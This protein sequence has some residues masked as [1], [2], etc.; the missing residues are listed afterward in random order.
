MSVVVVSPKVYRWQLTM[1]NFRMCSHTGDFERIRERILAL[2][3]GE[4]V[5]NSLRGPTRSTVQHR[6]RV[7]KVSFQDNV[8]LWQVDIAFDERHYAVMQVVKGKDSRPNL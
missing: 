5:R 6:V 1:L 3:S 4:W 7:Y 2:A 8:I